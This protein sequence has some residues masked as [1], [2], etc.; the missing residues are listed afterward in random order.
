LNVVPS[1]ALERRFAMEITLSVIIAGAALVLAILSP[2]VSATITTRHETKMFQ[3]RLY[4]EKRLDTF[5]NYLSTA[6]ESIKSQT[7]LSRYARA[8][9]EVLLFV[10][11]SIHREMIAVNDA[12]QED[13]WD[14]ASDRIES[15]SH[16]LAQLLQK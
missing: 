13:R 4:G 10:T 15:I 1:I 2:V 12:F 8:Y 5:Q 16:D 11:D 14:D 3:R 9:G 6:R 7:L